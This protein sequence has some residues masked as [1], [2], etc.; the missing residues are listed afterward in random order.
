MFPLRHSRFARSL[1]VTLSALAILSGS[2]C[3]ARLTGPQH[4]A[5]SARHSATRVQADTDGNK[6]F[7]NLE[8]ALA[9]AR[10]D[11]RLD[12]IVRYRPG[13]QAG[14]MLKARPGVRGLEAD[15]SVA[16]RLTPS[17]IR[18][19]AASAAV[20]SIEAN[21]RCYATRDTAEASFG[22]TKAIADFGLSGD[23]DGDPHH[24]SAQDL[25]IAVIDTG[26]DGNHPDFAGGKIIA[27]KD[28]RNGRS[29]PYDDAGHGTHC[30]SI[31]AGAVV[32]GV[33]GVAPGASLIGLKV[34]SPDE[35][36]GTSGPSDVVAQAVDWCVQ[37]R[38]RYGIDVVTMSLSSSDPSNGQDLLSRAVDRAVAAGLVVCVAAGNDGPGPETIGSPSAAAGAITVG[39]MVDLGKGGFALV[40]SSSRGPTEDGRVKPDLCA[41]GYEILAAKANST[42]YTRMTGTS[43][44]CPFVAG[45]AALVLQADPSLSPEQVKTIL[46]ETAVHFGTEGENNDFGAGRLDAYA[47]IAR[48]SGTA[49]TP[50]AMPDHLAGL[51]YLPGTDTQET[52]ELPV[53]DTRFPLAVTVNILDE[54]ADFDL[55]VYDPDGN[56][57][58]ASEE[59][60]REEFVLLR[61]ARTGTYSIVVYSYDGWGDYC[62]DVSAGTSLQ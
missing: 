9:A 54:E 20:E 43:M 12:V 40:P 24:Y 30:A 34:L 33:G 13:S 21:V 18:R 46:K 42:G 55:Y 50:P 2:A 25:T 35:D 51:G 53:D 58:G 52:W 16:V 39:N 36:G 41:P 38:A 31:A 14:R 19:L 27:W 3:A 26:I 11:Q 8:G 4:A 17:E 45:V 47:A 56:L 15:H 1:P 23:A 7:D 22:V 10:P 59:E 44:A 49:G 28:F 29:S 37:N 62:L 48:A 5:R 61:P 6:L 57:V 32:S 60:E